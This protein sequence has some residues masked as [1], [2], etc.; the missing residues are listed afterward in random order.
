MNLIGNSSNKPIAARIVKISDVGFG[1]LKVPNQFTRRTLGHSVSE[2]LKPKALAALVFDTIFQNPDRASKN[3]NR[4]VSGN[5]LFLIDHDLAFT[6]E[7]VL[8]WE[9]PWEMGSL[10]HFV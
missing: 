1:S 7:S 5:Q 8:N 10:T 6:H 2:S 3:P 9:P 4:L